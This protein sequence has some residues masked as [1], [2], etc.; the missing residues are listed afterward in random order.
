MANYNGF[1]GEFDISDP[2]RGFMLNADYGGVQCFRWAMVDGGRT[3]KCLRIAPGGI[4]SLWVGCDAV[5]VLV[6]VWTKFGTDADPR[7]E[8]WD[9]QCGQRVAS[10]EPVGSGSD[11][12][13]II[14]SFTAE[15]KIY[16]VKMIN[17]G[18]KDYSE[19]ASRI[20]LFDDLLVE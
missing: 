13:K 6:S 20:A 1:W 2:D 11:F 8:V 14:A 3:G 15:K 10:A 9:I 7:L 12:E 16:L 4:Y 19:L 5:P 18:H 17:Y